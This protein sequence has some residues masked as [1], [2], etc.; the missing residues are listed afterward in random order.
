MG[1]EAKRLLGVIKSVAIECLGNE[2]DLLDALQ[3]KI[4]GGTP[5]VAYDGFECS[6]RMHIA[7]GLLRTFSV[8]RLVAAGCRFRFWVAD[9]FAMLNNKLGG[10]L[11]KIRATSELIIETWTACGMDMKHV[12]FVWASEEIQKRGTEYWPLVLR[13]STEMS[14]T[15]V[16]KATQIMGRAEGSDKMPV[17]QALYAVMQCV[18][19]FFLDVDI[20]SL[21]LDQRKVLALTLDVAT[22]LQRRKPF[23]LMH[24]MLLGLTGRKMSKSDPDAAIF[25]DDDEKEVNRKLEKAFCP[26]GKID[27]NPVVEY[28]QHIVFPMIGHLSIERDAKHG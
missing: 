24:H 23:M 20:C 17:S 10:D 9:W 21:G 6:G 22:A 4:D 11:T 15:R 14:L 12:E 28:V 27:G 19:P 2:A 18:D 26:S 7:Q 3:R 16:K 5:L 13:A 1:D 25:M 8:N